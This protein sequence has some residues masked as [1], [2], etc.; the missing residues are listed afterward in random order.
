MTSLVIC[1]TAFTPESI[2]AVMLIHI[3]SSACIVKMLSGSQITKGFFAS[4]SDEKIQQRLLGVIFDLLVECK[5][6][7]CAQTINSV[8][9]AVSYLVVLPSRIFSQYHHLF[10]I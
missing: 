9:K 4:L 7:V 6:P 2:F 5:N 10:L 1:N 8:F 3:I